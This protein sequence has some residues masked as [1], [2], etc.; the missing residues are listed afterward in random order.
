VEDVEKV[1]GE[2]ITGDI[3]DQLRADIVSAVKSDTGLRK[4][5][6]FEPRTGFQFVSGDFEAWWLV[7]SY[8]ETGMLVSRNDDWRRSP[9]VNLTPDAV[10]NFEQVGKRK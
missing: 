6:P 7:S 5:C 10:R 4:A 3:L 8:C 9:L 2:E 1:P